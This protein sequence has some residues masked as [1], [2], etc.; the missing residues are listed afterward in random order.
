M[1]WLNKPRSVIEPSKPEL[2]RR[3]DTVLEDEQTRPKCDDDLPLAVGKQISCNTTEETKTQGSE[4]ATRKSHLPPNVDFRACTKEDIFH[5]KRLISLLLPSPYP[6]KFYREIIED[7]LSNNITLLAV[8][9]DDPAMKGKEKGRLVGA[10]RCRLLAHSPA[11]EVQ[12][13]GRK[14]PMLYLSTLV[15]LSPYRNHGIAAHLLQ[16]LTKR[17]IEDYGISRV[18]AHVWVANA[19]GLDWYTK[20][21]FRELTKESGY[22]RRLDPQDAVVLQK[23]VG[24]SDLLPG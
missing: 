3:N 11:A 21:G 12:E 15:L 4:V 22:Y 24:P 1:T 17:A 8:W 14:G 13:L 19:E 6:D 18:G 23:D 9:H 5:L 10:I 16:I 20:R 7:P 2:E